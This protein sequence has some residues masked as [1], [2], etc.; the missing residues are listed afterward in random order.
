MIKGLSRTKRNLRDETVL[1]LYTEKN[2]TLQEI[3]DEYG[4]TRERV[5]QIINRQRHGKTKGR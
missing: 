5:R 4:I 2:K 3:A 1:F